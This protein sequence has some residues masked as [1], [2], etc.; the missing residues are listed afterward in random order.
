MSRPQFVFLSPVKGLASAHMNFS[1]RFAW[2][3]ELEP[4]LSWRT[5]REKDRELFDS[6]WGVHG[7]VIAESERFQLRT[8]DTWLEGEAADQDGVQA[9]LGKVISFAL[10]ASLSEGVSIQTRF[11]VF[12]NREDGPG[13]GSHSNFEDWVRPTRVGDHSSVTVDD[14][15]SRERIRNRYTDVRRAFRSPKDHAFLRGVGRYRGA[16][17]SQFVEAAAILLCAS[18]E[19]LAKIE[20]EPGETNVK[21]RLI[22]KYAKRDGAEDVKRAIINRLYR[23][24]DD[25]AHG[26]VHQLPS[27]N[28]REALRQGFELTRVILRKALADDDL[29]AAASEGPDAMKAYLEGE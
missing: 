9:I 20:G 11:M 23:L 10:A 13:P 21:R 18:M 22:R 28:R 4:G 12:E 6:F 26:L 14:E 7:H 8:A 19:A 27:G 16:L 17:F 5:V 2:K 29:Y 1:P 24:R 3:V 15:E 25:S